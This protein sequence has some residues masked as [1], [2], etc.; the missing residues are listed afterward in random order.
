[1]VKSGGAQP[2]PANPTGTSSRFRAPLSLLLTLAVVF[3]I[4]V[5]G[6]PIVFQ[7]QIEVPSHVQFASA[8]SVMFEIANQN[9]TP[10]TNVE[11]TCELSRLITPKGA[12]PQPKVVSRGRFPKVGARRG[13]TGRCQT[14]YLVPPPVK[15]VE[16]QLTITYRAYPW[17]QQRTRV[18]RISAQ[19][20]GKGEVTGWQVD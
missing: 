15:T 5:F 19:I 18:A 2:L 4:V 20:S 12:P 11:Y 17:P 14:G 3:L 6:F 9:L 1:M 16:Y 8:S 13:V 10:L 7:L